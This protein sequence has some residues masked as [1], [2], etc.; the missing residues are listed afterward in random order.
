MI[1]AEGMDDFEELKDWEVC[2][3]I[4]FSRNDREATHM[5]LNNRLHTQDLYNDGT[6]SNVNMESFSGIHA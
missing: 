4:G 3:F 1:M 6:N 5:I 2:Y